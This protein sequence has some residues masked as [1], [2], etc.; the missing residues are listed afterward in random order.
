MTAYAAPFT[1]NKRIDLAKCG[2]FCL[3]GMTVRPAERAVLFNGTRRELQPRVMQVLIALAEKRTAVVSR[4]RVIELCWDGRIV[5]DDAL[6]RC[7]LA[8]RHLAQEFS[9]PPFTIETVP[10]IGHRLIENGYK[11]EVANGS[12]ISRRGPWIAITAVLLLLAIAAGL[13]LWP[14]R[15]AS[16]N[17]REASIAVLPFRNLGPG[18]PYFAEGVG[19]ETLA[20]LAR[21][22]QFRVTATT[23]SSQLPK[24]LDFSEIGRRLNAKYLLQ[25]S[26]RRQ[27]NRVRVNAD[28]VRAS[29]GTRLWS[30]TYDGK[31]DDIFLIQQ[32]IGGA[33]A[34]A[35]QR[36]LVRRARL[37]GP[38]VTNGEA[39]NL[40]L[41]ARGLIRT[42]SQFGIE[43]ASDLLRDAIKLD[44]NYAPAWSALAQSTYYGISADGSEAVIAALPRARAYA[45]RALQLAPQLADAH[46]ALG[47]LLPQGSPEAV[48]HLRRAAEL[49]PKNAEVLLGFGSALAASGDFDR[50]LAVYRRAQDADPLWFRPTG[51]LAIRLAETGRRA[52]AETIARRGLAHNQTNLHML[53]GRIDFVVGDYSET[54]RHWSI[55][56]KANSPRWTARG[57]ESIDEVKVILGLKR[58]PNGSSAT[59]LSLARPISV[60][61]DGP[62]APSAWRMRNRDPVAADVY[63]DDNHMS[64]K[65]MLNTDR[66][67]ELAATF[68]GPV[69]LLSLRS[70]EPVR[71]DQ[72][73]EVAVVALALR[74]AKR[75][76]DADQLLYQAN[77]RI[78][79]LYRQRAIPFALDADVAAIRAV[80]GKRDQALAMLDRAVKRG[81][82]HGGPTDLADL[83]A[84]PAFSTL[85]GDPR[86][87][88]IRARLAAHL[89]RERIETVRLLS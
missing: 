27:G 58:A 28:L 4:E 72:L 22:P 38:L 73:D 77:V 11:P 56:A 12:G 34:G 43:T 19:E 45:R 62:P 41:T 59:F 14:Q 42:R 68:D 86:F 24:G 9:P 6:N 61:N 79:V 18:D 66:A 26:V 75:Q 3:G 85:R 51:Q 82:T 44:P 31:L 32:R 88:R 15:S 2:E 13:F 84:E 70:T 47:I 17:A 21:E 78:A 29:D 50:E 30:D 57:Q 39:Y 10:R 33:I 87:E 67:R 53:L 74:Q 8:L 36:K 54:A 80:Q 65:L 89:V 20:Q 7:I 63:R 83:E 64:A 5:G 76:A 35:L 40:Y 55:V 69:G 25:G 49:D 16:D 23:S 60:W 81:W 37:A 71:A 52:E 48:A 46:L 1:A